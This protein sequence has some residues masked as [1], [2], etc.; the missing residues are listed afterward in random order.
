MMIIASVSVTLVA[1]WAA[2]LVL[3]FIDYNIYT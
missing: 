2:G 3:G 1:Y